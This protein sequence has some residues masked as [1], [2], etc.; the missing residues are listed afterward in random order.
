MTATAEPRTKYLPV[1]HHSTDARAYSQ[2]DS[3]VQEDGPV[4]HPLRRKLFQRRRLTLFQLLDNLAGKR[5]GA[6]AR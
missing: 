6:E 5:T 4:Q 3:L 2:N 1:V